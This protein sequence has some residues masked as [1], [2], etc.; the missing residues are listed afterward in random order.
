MGGNEASQLC[1]GS[2][3][4]R[5]GDAFVAFLVPCARQGAGVAST[6]AGC[7]RRR[8][9]CRARRR[10]VVRRER[11]RGTGWE[12]TSDARGGDGVGVVGTTSR[13]PICLGERTGL[14]TSL[15][16]RTGL[17][18]GVGLFRT[19]RRNSFDAD[20]HGRA[21]ATRSTI[22]SARAAGAAAALLSLL[23]RECHGWCCRGLLTHRLPCFV[24]RQTQIPSRLEP[25]S[26]ASLSQC[27]SSRSRSPNKRNADLSA[28]IRVLLSSPKSCPSHKIPLWLAWSSCGLRIHRAS[29]LGMN[30]IA[31]HRLLLRPGI[32]SVSGKPR[33]F[34]L[35]TN[36]IIRVNEL[37]V[38]FLLLL[39]LLRLLVVDQVRR[40]CRRRCWRHGGGR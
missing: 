31:Q 9:R 37:R 18:R 15:G 21:G 13:I 25:R 4:A 23:C 6:T 36:L 35:R 24:E 11:L 38:A 19:Y 3:T 7:E 2:E 33:H 20:T 10:S 32:K 40:C 29:D 27:P 26:L 1:G 12:G 17:F 30:G 39:L 22:V 28:A 34:L 8:R 5:A 14:T 16:K